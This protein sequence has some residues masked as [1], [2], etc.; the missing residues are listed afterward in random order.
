MSRTISVNLTA[1]DDMAAAFR[2]S[3]ASGEKLNDTLKKTG[4]TAELFSKALAD[5]EKQERATA[6][7]TSR[8][9][10]TM[11]ALEKAQKEAALAAKLLEKGELSAEEAAEKQAVA[12]KLLNKVLAANALAARAA[13]QANEE[14]A[15]E[16]RKAARA[17][18]G[19]AVGLPNA[20]DAASKGLK[21]LSKS[22]KAANAAMGK[23]GAV[24]IAAVI[25]GLASLPYLASV[26][27]A[28]ITAGVGGALIGIGVLG[29]AQSDAVKAEFTRLADHVK[30]VGV[31]MTKPFEKTLIQSL[32]FARK[33]FDDLTPTIEA[34]L[35]PLSLVATQFAKSFFES[36]TK[37]KP[38]IM[39]ITAAFGPLLSNLGDELPR[40]MGRLADA[41]SR[42]AKSTDPKALSTLLDILG[43]LVTGTGHAIDALSKLEKVVNFFRVGKDIASNLDD[44]AR[45]LG[46]LK[47]A[48]F[49]TTNPLASVEKNARSAA[50][51]FSV[52]GAGLDIVKSS[53]SA[54]AEQVA[55]MSTTMQRASLT[56]EQ[57]KASLDAL[58]G[59]TLTLRESTAAYEAAIDAATASMKE[60]GKAHGFATEK[61]R[62]NEE[63][64]NNLAKTAHAQAVAMRDSGK[65]AQ[66]VARH[67]EGA[68]QKFITAAVGMGKTRAQAIALATKLFGVRDAARSIPKSVV[69]N[70]GERNTKSTIALI[71][72]LRRE[73]GRIPRQVITDIITRHIESGT[74]RTGYGRQH[75][76]KG[77][78]VRGPGTGTSDSIPAMLSNGEFVVNSEAAGAYGP[79]LQA[80]NAGRMGAV[81]MSVPAAS[82]GTRQ[83]APAMS[84]KP[85]PIEIVI[86]SGGT[87]IDDLIVEIIRRS[88]KHRGGNVQTVLGR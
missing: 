15:E 88:V 44:F 55:K 46:N 13:A 51:G 40:F 61:G 48:A 23:L 57:L 85:S 45:G 9:K 36:L 52:A 64:L 67:M 12:D 56:A 84:M 19:L 1:R 8:V 75:H 21:D 54:S 80:I 34:S 30:K 22:G 41:L 87:K 73:Y 86:R 5:V 11:D 81:P 83:S 58:A 27:A 35:K 71:E 29:A 59:K 76:A 53:A 68:R 70:V 77:G 2:S 39:D 28:A 33:A 82:A 65:S 26:A 4:T 72:R 31:G 78:P 63:A 37:L 17:A 66:E 50:I 14:L 69:T 16:Q 24:G 43:L 60:N 47:E 38:A 62:E 42:I 6:R 18:S 49:G 25:V 32:K 74:A 7:E 20:T 79:L 3:A 10:S